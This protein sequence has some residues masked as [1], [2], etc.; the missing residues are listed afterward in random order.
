MASADSH[1]ASTSYSTWA[2]LALSTGHFSLRQ[3]LGRCDDRRHALQTASPFSACI[4]GYATSFSYHAGILC[5]STCTSLRVLNFNNRRTTEKVLGSDVFTNHVFA[6]SGREDGVGL[7]AL[8]SIQI[9]EYASDIVT[10]ACDFGLHGE[11][12]FAV[13]ISDRYHQASQSTPSSRRSRVLLCTRLRSSCKLFV[14]HNDRYLIL[15]THSAPSEHHYHEWLLQGY[16][17]ETSKQITK[18]P[19]QLREF[20][21]SEIGITVCFT[22]HQDKFYALTNQTSHES[23]EV[24]WTSYYQFISFHLQDPCPNLTIRA[25]WRRQH[26]E[27]PINDA[28][29]DLVFQQDHRSGELLIVECR[30]EWVNGGSRSIRTYYTQPF[31]RAT[32]A[33]LDEGLRHPPDD[34]LSRTLD[35]TSNS[36]WEK[37]KPRVSRHVHAEFRKDVDEGFKEYIRAKTKWNEYDFN[38]QSFVDLVVDEVRNEGD[39]RPKERVKV[40]V[41]SRDELS[42]LVPDAGCRGSRA[43][44]VRWRT[45]DKDGMAMED[46]EEAFSHSRV[47]LWPPDDAPQGLQD[48]LCPSGRSGEVKALLGD[49]GIVYM[50]GPLREAGSPERAL[51]FVSFDPTFGFEGMRRLDGSFATPKGRDAI[52]VEETIRKRKNVSDALADKAHPTGGLPEGV[53]RIKSE[54]GEGEGEGDGLSVSISEMKSTLN[55]ERYAESPVSATPA[56]TSTSSPL[57]RW[58]WREKAACLSIGNGYWVR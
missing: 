32:H 24:D 51:I 6:A 47:S 3:T 13:N 18:E 43:S 23:E 56:F 11:H 50:A 52:V 34:P 42:P 19:L 20:F 30:K 8:Q 45:Q 26:L 5:Y 16:D 9:H 38:A 21:G 53:K 55:A 22:I 57:P 35:K 44:I 39:W 25:I 14:R 33:E 49:E 15:G 54:A 41:V 58:T 37:P 1:Q 10:L 29:T 12:I 27:G 2:R 36:R 46:G 31:D 48:I 7:E 4:I 17:L 28:W 40:R